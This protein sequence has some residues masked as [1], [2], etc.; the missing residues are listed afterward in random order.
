MAVQLGEPDYGD[1]RIGNPFY[2]AIE[3][4]YAGLSFSP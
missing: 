3:R 1:E 2:V 4:G